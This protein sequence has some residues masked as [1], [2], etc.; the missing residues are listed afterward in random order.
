MRTLSKGTAARAV[1]LTAG[2]V[3]LGAGPVLPTA[4]LADTTSGASSVLGGN[5]VN[6]PVSAPIDVSGNAA[7]VAGTSAAS[8]K[9][10]ARTSGG[11]GGTG[12]RQAT[13]GKSSVGGGNQVNTPISVPVNVC[14]NAVAI[15]GSAQASCKGGATAAG[16]TSGSRQKTSG[17][18]SVLGGNQVNAPVSAPIDVCGNAVAVLG[19]AQ[20]GCKGGATAA[21][22][23]G[24][25]GQNTSGAGGVGSGNQVNAPI[26]VPVDVCG[27]AVGNA[28]AGCKGGASV[29][30]GGSGYG[31]QATSGAGAVLSGNQAN[32]PVAA[33]VS[34]CGNAA[35]IVGHTGAFC[36]GGA[37]ARNGGGAGQNTSGAGGV[38]AGNQAN[39]PVSI[40]A[41]ACGNAAALLGVAAA[42][43]DGTAA[44][45]N[46]HGSGGNTSGNGPAGDGNQVNTPAKVPAEVCGNAAAVLGHSEPVCQDDPYGYGPRGGDRLPV[47][48][49]GNLL[50][51]SP[52]AAGKKALTT[53]PV[54]TLPAPVGTGLHTDSGSAVP[55]TPSTLPPLS[56]LTPGYGTAGYGPTAALP[57]DVPKLPTA[58]LPIGKVPAAKLPAGKVP[59][60]KLP[61]GKVPAAKLPIGKVPAGELPVGKL[62]TGK[63]PAVQR[64]DARVAPGGGVPAPVSLGPDTLPAISKGIGGL[65]V[66]PKRAPLI[67]RHAPSGTKKPSKPARLADQ[68]KLPEVGSLVPGLK[69]PQ[70]APVSL[71]ATS[72][73][74]AQYRLQPHADEHTG[75]QVP[76]AGAVKLPKPPATG[77]IGAPKVTDVAG[78][79]GRDAAAAEG[80]VLKTA[81]IKPVS[82]ETALSD[83]S[84]KGWWTVGAVAALAAMSGVLSLTR[85]FRSHRG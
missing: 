9:G 60:A 80:A 19:V 84:A 4:A 69:L 46:P 44:V 77:V 39:A 22:G 61:A 18:S 28:L 83:G 31:G 43:C 32:A 36:S 47:Q 52:V 20:A 65:P 51:G 75:P 17:K 34:I 26:S 49:P 35:A 6:A 82:A 66:D 57:V 68:P 42:A 12:S 24:S 2:F 67:H 73:A 62:P 21:N 45:T 29:R 11:T 7:A 55:V 5:Q 30:D 37:H 14:G 41:N 71:P 38:G 3:A 76:G 58:K 8:S 74:P 13:S 63:L 53:A 33:P 59:A 25:T 15:L 54:R 64:P 23:G 48:V 70:A 40:P 56:L 72:V 50:D 10:G 79:V 16:G 27:N 85:R 78:K 1:L 81:A